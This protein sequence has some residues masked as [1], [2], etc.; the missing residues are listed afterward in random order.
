MANATNG[1]S[2]FMASGVGRALRVLAGVGLA[3]WGFRMGGTAGWIVLAVGLIPLS[4][5]ALDLCYLSALFGGPLDGKTIRAA[6]VDR[7]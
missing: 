3:V 5:G 6:A 4:A 7:R 2:R 1:I